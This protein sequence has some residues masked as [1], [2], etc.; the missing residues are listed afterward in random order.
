MVKLFSVII[1]SLSLCSTSTG[2][3]STFINN[4]KKEVIMQS[5]KKPSTRSGDLIRLFQDGSKLETFFYDDL[6]VTQIVVYNSSGECVYQTF[7][8]TNMENHFILDLYLCNEGSYN[9]GLLTLD[10]QKDEKIIIILLFIALLLTFWWPIFVRASCR[11][12]SR[13]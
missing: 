3:W 6:G 4:S 11:R 13:S 5:V 10:N 12:K 7:T 8:D 1:L 2:D 9:N